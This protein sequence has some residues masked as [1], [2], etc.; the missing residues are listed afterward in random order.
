MRV[1]GKRG[2]FATGEMWRHAVGVAITC[3]V[4]LTACSASHHSDSSLAAERQMATYRQRGDAAVDHVFDTCHRAVVAAS[5]SR[6]NPVDAYTLPAC[7]TA[8]V[9]S[10]ISTARRAASALS[11]QVKSSRS[12]AIPAGLKTDTIHDLSRL[13]D[14][15]GTWQQCAQKVNTTVYFS[16]SFCRPQL[17][18][19]DKVRNDLLALAKRWPNPT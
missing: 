2:F 15:F 14:A 5:S 17:E 9:V 11:E 19:V 16:G 6:N 13:A 1:D 4:A 3:F 18:S 7:S 8:V 10:E 12:S